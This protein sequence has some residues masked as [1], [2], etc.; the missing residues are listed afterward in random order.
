MWRNIF[1]RE[2]DQA[3]TKANDVFITR[4]IFDFDL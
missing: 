1:R 2:E 3:H 4:N